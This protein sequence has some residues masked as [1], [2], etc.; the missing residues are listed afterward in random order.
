MA[1]RRADFTDRDPDTEYKYMVQLISLILQRENAR[2]LISHKQRPQLDQDDETEGDMA[3]LSEC[4]EFPCLDFPTGVTN[5][6]ANI[7]LS[8]PR[9]FP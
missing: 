7:L 3:L 5:S 8:F 2:I 6:V 1:K 4:S 9:N